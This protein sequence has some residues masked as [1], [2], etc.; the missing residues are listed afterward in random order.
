M[1]D[2]VVDIAASVQRGEASAE[3]VALRSLERIASLDGGVHAFLHVARDSAL[4]QARAQQAVSLEMK[5]AAETRI[6]ESQARVEQSAPVDAQLAA[7]RA[8]G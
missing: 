8:N 5:R 4:A 3:S 2:G 1:L 7:A 6:S